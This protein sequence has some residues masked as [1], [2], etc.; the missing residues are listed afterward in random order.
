MIQRMNIVDKLHQQ[1]VTDKIELLRGGFDGQNGPL[2]VELDTTEVCNLA[3][4]GCIS[5]DLVSNK[6]SFSNERLLEIGKELYE[7]GVK[8]VVLIGGGEPLAHPKAGELIEYLGTHDIHVGI[9]TNGYFIDRY[10]DQI[11]KYSKWTR[12]SMDASTAETFDKLRPAKD[13]KSKFDKI[14]NN[15]RE[16]AKVK[17]GNLGFSFL[18]RTEA[19]GF[20]IESNVH[21]I[22]DA[23][24]LARDIG[25]D[26]FEVK[27]SYSYTGG[28]DHAL[29]KHS[30]ERMAEAR[31]QVDRLS[32]LTTDK[33]RIIKA[34]NLE[35]SLNCVN[36]KQEKS[37]HRC[38][39]SDLRTLICPSGVYICPYW[40]GKDRFRIGNAHTTSIHDI[41]NSEQRRK[42]M[43]YA[44]PSKVCGFHC[45]RDES[46][47]EVMR[48]LEEGC[49]G[50]N[51]LK[52]YDRFI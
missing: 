17:K 28:Q 1:F 41:W 14:V 5:E 19:D 10:M 8:A 44:D 33:F 3:C 40:R 50:I 51:I 11:A 49:A 20:G 42:I 35:D 4:P 36:H 30:P 25:C 24:K 2:V 15:M 21:E 47:T 39:V 6:T 29:V 43:E 23:A 16:L 27:P 32:E 45:L 37:Y 13:G 26:Y 22:Y 38:V 46:N 52:E 31:I 34:I 9:T 18:I 12:I 48:M 7:C